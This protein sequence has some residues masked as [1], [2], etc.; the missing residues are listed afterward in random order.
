MQRIDRWLIEWA[1][2]CIARTAD[3]NLSPINVVEKLLRDPGMSTGKSQD[4]I[5]FWH[6][7]P[8]I[9]AVSKAMHQVD[10]TSQ[11]I[12]IVHYGYLPHEGRKYTMNDLVRES[13]LTLS[14]CRNKRRKARS[15]INKIISK[16]LDI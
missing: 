3:S 7:N 1:E 5:L 14:E 16:P 6:R 10:A 2:D 12:L 15:K 8:R 9:A 13:S 11:V 4:K